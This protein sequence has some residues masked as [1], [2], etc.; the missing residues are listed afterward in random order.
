MQSVRFPVEASA[1]Y[2]GNR[3]VLANDIKT[4]LNAVA[5]ATDQ[6]FPKAII[7]PHAGYLYSG[8]TAAIAYVRLVPGLKSISLTWS[9]LHRQI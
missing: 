6:T 8:Q 9:R 2:S 5:P 3:Q 7:V 4:F 1:F